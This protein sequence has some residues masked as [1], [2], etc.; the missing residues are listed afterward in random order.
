MPVRDFAHYNIRAPRELLDRLCAFYQDVVGLTLGPRPPF[1]RFGYWLYAGDRPV[2]HLGEAAAH[3]TCVPDVSGTF[4][5]AAFNCADRSAFERRLTEMRVPYRTAEV[6]LTGQI[7][8]FCRDPAG[9]GV[10]L[11]FASDD[12]ARQGESR[13]CDEPD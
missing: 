13:N 6:P 3:E 4:N 8:L 7:Q 2:L 11:C 10:E 12:T 9:N 5:H 1:T